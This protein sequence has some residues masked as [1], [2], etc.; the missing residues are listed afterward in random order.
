MA[1]QAQNENGYTGGQLASIFVSALLGYAMDGYNL[2]ILSFLMPYIAST[3]HLSEVAIGSVFSIQLVGSMFGGV[4]FGW[5]ADTIGRRNALMLSIA[6]YSVGALLSGLSGSLGAL[7]AFRALTGLGLGGEWGIGMVLFNEAWNPRRRG[8]GA[9]II[10]SSFLAGISL[11][12]I[13]AARIIASR[14]ANGWHF[15]LM[16]G[17]VPVILVLVIRLW[18]PESKLW[19]SFHDLK[20]SGTLPDEKKKESVPLVEIFRG[21]AALWSILGL[22]LVGGFMLAFYSVVTFMPTIIIKVFHQPPST[23]SSVDT[24]VTW[25]AI[26]FYILFGWMSDTVGRKRAF[27]I[28][29]GLMVIGAIWLLFAT[30]STAPVPS[31]IWAW[32]V[33][34]AYLVWYV[35]TS[36]S[37]LFGV[38]LSEVFPVEIRATAVSVTYMV[39]RGAS[40]I[41]PVLVP[42]MAAGV[43]GKGLGIMG[44]VG[45]CLML[46]FGL[47]LPETRGRLF[48][49][50]DNVVQS[51][52]GA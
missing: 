29:G 45:A 7:L 3:L 11:A 36:S 34:L 41:S 44:F 17:V 4:V 50:I 15:A 33:F 1:S 51:S 25:I 10:Q 21:R 27:A 6:V 30:Q 2:L 46:I 24:W 8:F 43:L 16:T 26:A 23:F 37:A 13:V 18:M 28:P 5:I 22:L 49:V 52:K 9:G 35:G 20:K 31:S 14:G 38:W 47:L 48:H 19:K 39:G 32:P 42:L 12:G 40:A